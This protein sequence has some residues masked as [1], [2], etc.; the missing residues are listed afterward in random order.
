MPN[1]YKFVKSIDA[2]RNLICGRLRFSTISELNDPCELLDEI[3]RDLV[4][5]SLK[6][7][8]KSGYSD[9]EYSW[10]QKQAAIL[11]AL[12]PDKQAI[13]LPVSAQDAHRQIMS[14][15]YDNIDRMA[16]L[17]RD[18]VLEIRK[19][20]GILSLSLRYDSLPMW[21]HYADNARGF[22][23]IFKDLEDFFS[24]DETGVLDEVKPVIYS[25]VFRGMTFDPSSQNEL[26]FWKHADWAYEQ[27]VRVVSSLKKCNF[28]EI[29]GNNMFI[30]SIDKKY[31]SGII[32]GWNIDK[33]I[34]SIAYSLISDAG[35]PIEIFQARLD[36]VTVVIDKLDLT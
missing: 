28:S 16:Q 31:I 26:F 34:R 23:V 6:R 4:I 29:N 11:Y 20:S 30:R 15:F 9:Y 10:L 32:L 2:V 25:N 33:S 27:E 35:R 1:L 22:V 14:S 8:R 17:Q 21:A 12:A 7:I 24:G 18:A 3:N 5:E 13:P 19:I 36:K